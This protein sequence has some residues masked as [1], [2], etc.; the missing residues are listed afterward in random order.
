MLNCPHASQTMR[1]W[2]IERRRKLKLMVIKFKK[3]QAPVDSRREWVLLTRDGNKIIAMVGPD[4]QAGIG[5]FGETVAAALR[6][7]ANRIEAEKYPIPEMD[8]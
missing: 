4:L 8:F 3:P 1:F 6:E 5:G 2:P 7:L